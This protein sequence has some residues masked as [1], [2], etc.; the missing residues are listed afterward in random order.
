MSAVIVYPGQEVKL[1]AAITTRIGS[2]LVQVQVSAVSVEGKKESVNVVLG[3]RSGVLKS[4]RTGSGGTS[5]WIQNAQKMY[6]PAIDDLVIGT[7]IEKHQENY[8][9]DFGSTQPGQLPATAFEG[10]TRRNKPNINV[11]ALV[12]CRVILCDKDM[13]PELTCTS[14]HFKKDWVTGESLFGELKGGYQF[15]CSLGLARKLVTDDCFVLNCLGKLLPFELAVGANGRVWV[16]SAHTM[17]TVL[18]SNAILNS[19]HMSDPMIQNLVT[20]LV[21]S[22]S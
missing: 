6:V 11:G 13:E 2:G 16:N 22:V 18:I 9:I 19:E 14:E 3:S 7:V 4:D 1:D 17:H 5:T 21:Q 20:R 10:A 8:R 15:E 12:Y